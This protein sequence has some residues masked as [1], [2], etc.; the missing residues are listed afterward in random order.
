MTN[1]KTMR[2]RDDGSIEL[3][4][5]TVGDPGDEEV[6][7]QGGACGICSW[8]IVTAKLGS[9]MRPMAPP[10]HEGIGY[11][12]RVGRGVQGLKEGDRV[13]GGGFATLRNL[14]AARVYPVPP[15]DLA[16][17]YWLVEP[18]SCAV[19]GLD[20][21]RLRPGDRVAVI[22]AG[23]MGL[24]ILQGL[25][26]APVDQLVAVDVAQDRLDLARS[27]GVPET[28]NAARIERDEL[29]QTLHQRG[30]DVVVDASGSQAGLD[31]ATEIVK[32]G[33][34]INLFGWIKG[35][36]AAFDPTKWHL[37]GFTV[38]NSSPSSQLR[39]PF[40]AA[41]RLIHQGVFDLRPLVTDV[42]PLE[43]YPTLMGKIVH[44]DP[45]YIK[46]VITLGS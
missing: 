25:L 41:I 26:H 24:L 6:Q 34:L 8:D 30:Y 17:A 39:D 3:L 40:P 2:Y 32:R 16:D 18:V 27:L 45:R 9:Q 33:G 10:G 37:G 20:H 35:E 14:P 11:V 46:G 36:T 31:L 13:A 1:A 38:V 44:G 43:D 12:T 42:V 19:T 4:A 28:F 29:V 22:G 23:F 15:S 21:C 7:V 5:V